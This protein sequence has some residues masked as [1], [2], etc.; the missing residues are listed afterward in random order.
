M[1]QPDKIRIAL[2]MPGSNAQF[3]RRFQ[4]IGLA[5]GCTL[6]SFRDV[7]ALFNDSDPTPATLVMP[8]DL[9]NHADLD[10]KKFKHIV[11]IYNGT[12]PSTRLISQTYW[13]VNGSPLDSA[14][15]ASIFRTI[16]GM[17]PSW[18]KTIQNAW[19]TVYFNMESPAPSLQLEMHKILNNLRIVNSTSAAA[20][21]KAV[22]SVHS[23]KDTSASTKIEVWCDGNIWQ[24][25]LE[26]PEDLMT[27][28]EASIKFRNIPDSVISIT[29]LKTP[30]GTQLE[31]YGRCLLGKNATQ[32]MGI[33]ILGILPESDE[34]AQSTP[35]N[36][37][38]SA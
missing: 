2:L 14:H 7:Q 38:R 35:E 19:S 26:M 13:Q 22:N 30:L 36:L 12:A 20:V 32:Q 27:P 31:I 10:A 9:V 15:T 18:N 4:G 28:E 25:R 11:E 23:I 24:F 37:E 6:N 8:A 21:L 5:I 16:L 29:P 3:A 1:V 34:L 17:V 33:L